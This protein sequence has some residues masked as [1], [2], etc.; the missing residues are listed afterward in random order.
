MGLVKERDLNIAEYLAA[1]SETLMLQA[2]HVRVA[3]GRFPDHLYSS[4][5]S[6]AHQKET[7]LES[8]LVT[9]ESELAN[10]RSSA[11]G[12]FGKLHSGPSLPK[13]WRFCKACLKI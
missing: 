8:A 4:P 12:K 13:P 7:A 6:Q 2:H 1:K 9:V 10:K 11:L 3:E 5:R